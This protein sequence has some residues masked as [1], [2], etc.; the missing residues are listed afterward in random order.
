M[1]KVTI[2]IPTYNRKTYLA[3]CIKSI[4]NQ[5]FKDFQIIVFDNCSD[6]NIAMFLKEFNDDRIILLR[7]KEN[8]SIPE[9]FGRIFTYKFFSD[10]LVIF[11]D[12]DV[13]HPLLLEKEVNILDKHKDVVFVGTNLRPVKNHKEM[14]SFSEINSGES[15]YLCKKP[16]DLVR[17]ILKGFNLCFDSVMYRTSILEDNR[18]LDKKFFKWFD[19]PYLIELAKNGS[20]GIIDDKLVNYRL[21]ESQDSQA[22]SL[23]KID[24]VFNLFLFYKEKL[25]KPLSKEDKKLFY[26]FATNNLILFGF[27]FLKSWQ[28]YGNFLKKVRRRKD[29]FD[30]RYLT[31][32]GIYSFLKGIKNLYFKK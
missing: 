16:A 20:V 4:L 22:G 21:H 32:G 29:I 7:S 8:I 19:R 1:P 17:L 2:A 13:M 28:E 10:Y 25:I 30:L 15:F 27:S 18:P 11:H 12:D 6:Y 14:F 5:T 26:S 31:P 3:E 9:N 23:D 24:C